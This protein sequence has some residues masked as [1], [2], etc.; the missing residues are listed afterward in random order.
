MTSTK[1]ISPREAAYLACLNFE[2]EGRYLADF[3]NDWFKQS[4]PSMQD[5]KLAQEIAYGTCRMRLALEYYAENLS[6]NKLNLKRKERILL[7]TSLYQYYF[8]DKIPLYALTNESIKIAKKYCHGRF[9]KFL[10]AVLRI[11]S[12]SNHKLP[13]NNSI[14]NFSI[15]YSYPE[16]YVKTICKENDADQAIKILE[17]GNARP[18]LMA[19][20]REDASIFP[21]MVAL[22]SPELNEFFSTEKYYIQ[23]GTPA[24]LMKFLAEGIITPKKILDL[25]AAPGGKLIA[26]HD[27]FPNSDL[28]ANDVSPSKIKIL[29]ENLHKY[30]ITATLSSG[31]GEDYPTKDLFDLVVLDVPCSN[32][33]VLNKRPEARWRLS[34][35]HVSEL[36]KC[37][38]KLLQ[39]A[40]KLLSNKGQIWYMTCS[41]LQEENEK[42]IEKAVKE[43]GLTIKKQMKILPNLEGAD[44][45]YGVAL[46]LEAVNRKIL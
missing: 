12:S 15:R 23:N 18:V 32:T 3:L 36:M 13:Q 35:E 42:L 9:I 45:G 7:F 19:R 8:L 41:I 2:K 10:N 40:I 17:A 4:H 27:L 29:E 30:K 28:Y 39:H 16:Y 46:A 31:R 14:Q 6:N 11:L 26:C 22:N 25:C 38:Y 34:K 43:L 20:R 33:G 37:Q 21:E 24:L 5:F 44:G 1:K